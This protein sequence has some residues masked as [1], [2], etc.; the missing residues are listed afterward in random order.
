MAI[1]LILFRFTQVFGRLRGTCVGQHIVCT[2]ALALLLSSACAAAQ[3]RT[4]SLKAAYLYYFTKFVYWPEPSSS[5]KICVLGQG[6]D[7]QQELNK[8]ALKSEGNIQLVFVEN[9]DALVGDTRCDLAFLLDGQWQAEEFGAGTLLV[10]D[11]NISHP[12]AVVQLL[13]NNNKLAFDINRTNAKKRNLEVS[14]KLLG[15]A[16]EVTD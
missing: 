12:D 1:A 9:K 8:V 15:L 13:L 7:I 16:R 14:A 3:S 2:V 4:A 11:E 6:S 5:R 10:V